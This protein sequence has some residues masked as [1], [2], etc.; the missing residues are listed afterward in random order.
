MVHNFYSLRIHKSILRVFI[1]SKQEQTCMFLEFKV[2]FSI[3]Y[4]PL[5]KV[6][7]FIIGRSLNF[8]KMDYFVGVRPFTTNYLFHE[9]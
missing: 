6:T 8:I 7:N 5:L 4:N 2:H 1:I 3:Y 9:L